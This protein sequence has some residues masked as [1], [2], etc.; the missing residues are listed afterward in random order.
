MCWEYVT[1]ISCVD[2]LLVY[3]TIKLNP[4]RLKLVKAIWPLFL[5]EKL[6]IW[7]YYMFM[8]YQSYKKTYLYDSA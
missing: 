1:K 2:T 6:G 7:H 8:L 3:V 5:D 4:F